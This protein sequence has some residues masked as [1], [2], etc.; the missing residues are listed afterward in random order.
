MKKFKEEENKNEEETKNNVEE[1]KEEVA[2]KI[3]NYINK[4]KRIKNEPLI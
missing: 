4:Y 1:G 2:E 3:M